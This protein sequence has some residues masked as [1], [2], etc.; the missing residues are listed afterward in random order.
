LSSDVPSTD[1]YS[2]D[3][4]Q[5]SLGDVSHQEGGVSEVL[6]DGVEVAAGLGPVSEP[7]FADELVRFDHLGF[8]P[9][10]LLVHLGKESEVDGEE[11]VGLASLHQV[12]VVVLL[13]LAFEAFAGDDGSVDT[14]DGGYEVVEVTD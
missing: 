4:T 7:E 13:F 14:W 3:Y 10:D 12:V 2:V 1:A 6:L 11:D 8:F 5:L 9:Q